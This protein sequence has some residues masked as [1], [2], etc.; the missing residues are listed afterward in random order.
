MEPFPP[1]TLMEKTRDLQFL[2]GLTEDESVTA[3]AGGAGGATPVP[4]SWTVF[5]VVTVLSKSTRFAVRAPAAFG[6]NTMPILQLSPEG[7][8]APAVRLQLVMYLSIT[9]SLGLVPANI[10]ALLSVRVELPVLETVT[11]KGLLNPPVVVVPV[12]F[13]TPI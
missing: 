13:R 2:A 4:E 8:I 9:K 10:A 12:K 11:V 6:V 7:R 5:V 3:G 1:T